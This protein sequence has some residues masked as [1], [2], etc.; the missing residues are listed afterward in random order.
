MFMFNRA[1]LM[2]R[3]FAL[4]E[5]LQ[6]HLAAASADQTNTTTITADAAADDTTLEL[7]SVDDIF[8]GA[9]LAGTGLADNTTVTAVNRSTNVVTL[10]Q[11]ITDDIA[12]ADEVEVTIT[13]ALAGMNFSLS[14]VTAISLTQAIIGLRFP[15]GNLSG[16][17]LRN[18][19]EAI[20]AEQNGVESRTWT[21]LS[22]VS[23]GQSIIVEFLVDT[24]GL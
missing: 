3:T 9:K 15:G 5:A 18:F 6:S 22:A 14:N 11:G 19:A 20:A 13:S 7:D 16:T 24:T 2:A 4:T 1:A 23:G 12:A 10:D 21:V 17:A 8:P